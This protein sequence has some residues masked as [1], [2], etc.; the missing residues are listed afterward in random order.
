MRWF[1]FF[2]LIMCLSLVHIYAQDSQLT[3]EDVVSRLIEYDPQVIMAVEANNKAESTYQKAMA[4]AYPNFSLTDTG[5]ALSK[6]K[7]QATHT[8]KLGLK[9]SQKLPTSGSLSVQLKDSLAIK[10]EEN[11][12]PT[13]R[14]SPS[15][16]LTLTQP[17]LFNDKLI[18]LDVFPAARRKS[19]IDKLTTLESG[20]ETV[21]SRIAATL[22]SYYKVIEQRK[23]IQ[24]QER[25]IAWHQRDLANLEKKQTLKLA[26]ETEVWEKRLEIADLEEDIFGLRLD[27]QKSESAMAHSLGLERLSGVELVDSISVFELQESEEELAGRTLLRNPGIVKQELSLEKTRMQSMVD[28][29]SY[30]SS[31]A[32]VVSFSPSYS[33]TIYYSPSLGES[34]T[35]Y[36]KADADYTFSVSLTFTIPLYDGD[37]RQHT[38]NVNLAAEQIAFESLSSEKAALL[39]DLQFSLLSRKSALDKVK[40]L[41][42]YVELNKKQLFI[43]KKLFELK[44]ITELE[45]ASVGLDLENQRNKLW[46][47]RADLFLANLNIY[48][49]SGE[50]LEELIVSRARD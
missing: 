47:A 43:Q 12:D 31:L 29:L 18:D 40:L 4:D 8:V 20:R 30:A 35:D 48:A 50:S 32:T 27:L 34:F 28:D 46:R 3:I 25:R 38:R 22:T 14:Q 45:V 7:D 44:Q 13:F 21:S 24:Y 39:R 36:G 16:S 10:V 41:E 11:E 1:I 17:F 9:Y 2:L 19:E 15:A 42:D 26:T 37:K 23:S 33:S 5:Y 49:N 6:S